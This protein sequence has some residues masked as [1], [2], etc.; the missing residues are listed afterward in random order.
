MKQ[1]I[2]GFFLLVLVGWISVCSAALADRELSFSEADIQ[3]ALLKSGPQQRNFGGLLS[4]ALREPPKINLGEVAGRVGLSARIYIS[5][6][7]NPALPV[8]ITGTAG[9][10]YDDT[11]KAFFL[12]K[13]QA[14]SVTAETMPKEAEPHARQAINAL[15]AAYFKTQPVY[16]LKENGSAEEIAA[17]WLLRSVRIEP[18]KVIAVLA[19]F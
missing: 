6:L 18:G 7:G 3:T 8:D 4:A 14:H 19:P 16:V 13:P 1:G 9:I 11:A 12:E 10:R 17:R 15:L 5:L 2:A